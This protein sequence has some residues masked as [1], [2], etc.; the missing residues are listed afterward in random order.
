MD[1]DACPHG[2]SLTTAHHQQIPPSTERWFQLA[3]KHCPRNTSDHVF[4]VCV[5]HPY[6]WRDKYP[7]AQRYPLPW[8]TRC[9]P[10]LK[11]HSRYINS[12][13]MKSIESA[14]I[15]HRATATAAF[16]NSDE[17]FD[18]PKCHP[19]TCIAVLKNI[20]WWIKWEEDLDAFIMWVYGPAGSGKSAIAQTIAEMCE[21]KMILLAS[22]FS[23]GT[24][25][26]AT[27]SSHLLPPSPTRS[28][29]TFLKS[30]MPFSRPSNTMHL[31]SLNLLL[32]KLN[33]SS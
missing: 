18:P 14:D 27:L 7:G 9:I 17:R 32:S 3:G 23:Q 4:H 31:S 12:Q 10:L 16:H 8:L 33:L 22:F 26:R 25:H 28:P 6:H 11:N 24:T 19:N 15:L 1:A 5:S 21:D 30:E 29:W 20:M 13:I 2:C